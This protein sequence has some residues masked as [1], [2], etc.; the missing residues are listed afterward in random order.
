MKLIDL[1]NEIEELVHRREDTDWESE[2]ITA[3]GQPINSV[4]V[5]NENVYMSKDFSK[6]FKEHEL[7]GHKEDYILVVS[8]GTIMLS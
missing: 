4:E 5:I 1:Y 8:K 7:P 6:I 3:D 2:V